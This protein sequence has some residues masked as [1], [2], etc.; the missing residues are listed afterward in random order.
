MI[1]YI[2]WFFQLPDV[3][4][5]SREELIKAIIDTHTHTRARTYTRAHTHTHARTQTHIR[6]CALSYLTVTLT[7]KLSLTL[8][9]TPIISAPG[10]WYTYIISWWEILSSHLLIS[11]LISHYPSR[12]YDWWSH[13]KHRVTLSCHDTYTDMSRKQSIFKTMTY[14]L[15]T[16][17]C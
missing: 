15:L 8:T 6:A 17:H 9:L 5:V 14:L 2:T 3:T 10:H 16:V 1:S 12:C 7:T 13:H 4:Q 11:Y